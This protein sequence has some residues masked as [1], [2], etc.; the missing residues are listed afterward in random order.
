MS[1]TQTTQRSLTA[2]RASRPAV[3][4]VSTADLHDA[5]E[6]SGGDLYRAKSGGSRNLDKTRSKDTE[7]I[8]AA[9]ALAPPIV[10]PT[11]RRGHTTDSPYLYLSRYGSQ[12]KEEWKKKKTS[13][14]IQPD[15]ESAT[16]SSE[17][18]IK[19]AR[20][21]RG[22]QSI[23][24]G[25]LH[26]PPFK[27][28]S[29][30]LTLLGLVFCFGP[31]LFCMLNGLGGGGLANPAPSNDALVANNVA[32]ALVGFFA[33][34]IVSKLGFRISLTL[35]GFGY[36]LYT[37]SLLTYQ[38]TGNGPFLITSGAILGVLC[39]LLWT[40]QGAML[41]SY[42]LPRYKG[43]YTSYVWTIFNLGAAGASLVNS[44]HLKSLTNAGSPYMIDCPSTKSPLLLW[45]H[46]QYHLCC[47]HLSDRPL[48]PPRY[49]HL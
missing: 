24:F 30:Q 28:P 9:I 45:Q 23:N 42:P 15:A 41:M 27:S 47:R 22:Y 3:F 25:P 31:G 7:P 11:L 13:Y 35:G 18:E 10:R 6:L 39:S 14:D 29:F 36:V 19:S 33:G 44:G 16:D 32:I 1:Y 26:F 17:D 40:A 46:I 8:P 38:I 5:A 20:K 2:R 37:S 21:G 43:R 49:V 12:H 4:D 34:P 48:L